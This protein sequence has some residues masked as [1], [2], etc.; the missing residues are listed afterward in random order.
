MKRDNLRFFI[1]LAACLAIIGIWAAARDD[2]KPA[3]TVKA[4]V[5]ENPCEELMPMTGKVITS[6]TAA[7][8]IF[9]DSQTDR[10]YVTEAPW[11]RAGNSMRVSVALAAFCIRNMDGTGMLRI[12]GRES[13]DT[14]MTVEDGHVWD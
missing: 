14:L 4:S 11:R 12:K 9:D 1:F 8:I 13:N 6:A 5:K 2:T 7:G 10:I 3:V